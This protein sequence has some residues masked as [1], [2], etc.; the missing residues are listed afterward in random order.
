MDL[1]H[2]GLES[3]ADLQYD[4]RKAPNRGHCMPQNITD[5]PQTRDFG[6]L[7]V[8]KLQKQLA[9]KHFAFVFAVSVRCFRFWSFR[10]R[11]NSDRLLGAARG[12][13]IREFLWESAILCAT[14]A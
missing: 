12:R 3:Q 6:P 9:P 14:S 1:G 7:A 10:R 11:A 13:L 5:E 2:H 4:V 8:Q